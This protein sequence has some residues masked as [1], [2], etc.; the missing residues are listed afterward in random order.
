MAEK[1]TK[2]EAVRRSLAKLGPDA[3]PVDIQKDV[4]DSFGIDMSTA[5]I[6]TTKGQLRRAANGKPATT[7]PEPAATPQPQAAEAPP[8]AGGKLTK[9][10]AV[11]RSLEKLGKGASTQELQVDVREQ[12][13]FEM[14]PDHVRN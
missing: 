14:S 8:T 9:V 2:Q 5:H 13:G 11:R 7:K 1:I 12:F 4:K 3:M 6:S 10:E